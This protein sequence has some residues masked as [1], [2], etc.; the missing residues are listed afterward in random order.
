MADYQILSE[1]MEKPFGIVPVSTEKIRLETEY[2]K[3]RKEISVANVLEIDNMNYMIHVKIPSETNMG[4][5]YDVVIHFFTDNSKVANERTFERYY[6]K[7][8][9]NSPSFTYRY[10]ALYKQ[11]GYLIDTLADKFSQENLNKMPEKTNVER[12]LTFDKSIYLAG[13][14]LLDNKLAN[15][16]KLVI[17][18][19]KTKN[20]D[21]ILADVLDVEEVTLNNSV[22]SFNRS[23]N[24][25][26]KKNDEN[27]KKEKN[28]S[29]KNYEHNKFANVIKPKK[30]TKKT[31]K[32]ITAKKT[33]VKPKKST[34]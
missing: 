33:T 13:R 25:E 27:I 26:I 20:I 32:K 7:L 22:A 21:K 5:Y 18:I 4:N 9:S 8:F 3:L 1:F 11:E 17:M 10:A 6:I 31:A 30:A 28:K 24:K 23:V 12:N 15:M 34:S 14:Y 16:N 29:K 19:K 2:T